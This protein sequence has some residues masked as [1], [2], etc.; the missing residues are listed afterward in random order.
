[1]GF[2]LEVP[3][4]SWNV[5]GAT[6]TKQEYVKISISKQEDFATILYE[7]EGAALLWT[8]EPLEF[9]LESRTKYYVKLFVRD[10]KREE[11]WAVTYFETGKMKEKWSANWIGQQEED[12][13]HPIFT[14][15]FHAEKEVQTARLY[16]CGLGMYEAY[17]N[18]S[19]IG[20]EVLSPF[21]NNYS[22]ALQVQTYDVTKMLDGNNQIAVSLG[23]GWYKGRLSFSPM[24][25]GPYIESKCR[26]KLKD[27]F[28]GTH[29]EIDEYMRRRMETKLITKI[30]DNR[31]KYPC[32]MRYADYSETVSNK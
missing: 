8:G 28:G 29:Y 10:D 9:T 7:K 3:D 11:A 22:N 13:F 5:E 1:M 27:E 6:G 17:L 25:Y 31:S 19:K 18:G 16:I 23:N 15:E 30:L 21:L 26:R 24:T 12:T 20:D 32:R 2:A 14:K 4:I